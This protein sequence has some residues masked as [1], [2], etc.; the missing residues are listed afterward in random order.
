MLLLQAPIHAKDLRGCLGLLNAVDKE[1]AVF[2][3]GLFPNAAHGHVK[4]LDQLNRVFFMEMTEARATIDYSLRNQLNLPRLDEVLDFVRY[5]G[6]PNIRIMA[7][8]KLAALP[9]IEKTDE[10]WAYIIQAN[11]F[12]RWHPEVG[13]ELSRFEK[14]LSSILEPRQR[15]KPFVCQPQVIDPS[16]PPHL[17]EEILERMRQGYT[18]RSELTAMVL[19]DALSKEIRILEIMRET[20]T[21]EVN[22][23]KSFSAFQK[24]YLD[25]MQRMGEA[26]ELLTSI[27]I[28]TEL[29]SIGYFGKGKI[30][31]Y[32]P[33]GETANDIHRSRQSNLSQWRAPFTP[34]LPAVVVEAG[35]N[36]ELVRA[37][38][39]QSG[40]FGGFY[41]TGRHGEIWPTYEARERMATPLANAHLEVARI[42]VT[43]GDE[44]VLG[45]INPQRSPN[46]MPMD[47]D[48]WS[49]GGGGGDAQYWRPD[50]SLVGSP[51][52]KQPY[53]QPSQV[54]LRT[55][56]I[57]SNPELFRIQKDLYSYSN[58]NWDS[59]FWDSKFYRFKD[60]MK[61]LMSEQNVS[62]RN[63]SIRDLRTLIDDFNVSSDTIF[64]FHLDEMRGEIPK[65]PQRYTRDF[66]YKQVESHFRRYNDRIDELSWPSFH[67]IGKEAYDALQSK[68]ISAHAVG[69]AYLAEFGIS[70]RQL[71]R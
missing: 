13:E 58:R 52:T 36:F 68:K 47:N 37:Y 15:P 46:G 34:G 48:Y 19:S 6:D 28:D 35:A 53:L 66:I 24:E 69:M 10:L 39:G 38:G 63:E 7:I 12:E 61:I 49:W 50:V 64:K 25:F 51:G 23:P 3:L 40:M 22:N 70:G 67:L 44:L 20:L 2:H 55:N 41:S 43:K 32:F 16:I 31:R 59:G 21:K 4:T 29:T 71:I 42:Q 60:Q 18:L 56:T 17:R 1:A 26:R 65:F 8:R 33:K 27:R 45:G 9:D 30:L 11:L 57:N 14:H 54:L 62:K 5:S